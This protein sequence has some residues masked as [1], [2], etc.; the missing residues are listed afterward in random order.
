M[1]MQAD[2]TYVAQRSLYVVL[3]NYEQEVCFVLMFW[4]LAILGYKWVSIWRQQSQLERDLLQL[5]PDL[6]LD[7]EDVREIAGRLQSLPSAEQEYLPARALLT[8]IERFGATNNVQDVA[9]ASREVCDS[10]AERQR[11]APS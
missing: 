11:E 3:R 6:P 2:K 5:P 4:A 7:Q 10:E 9:T 1:R 8:A